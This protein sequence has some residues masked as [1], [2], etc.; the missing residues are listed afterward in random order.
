[1]R[2]SCTALLTKMQG[3][4]ARTLMRWQS[5]VRAS[6]AT[7]QLVS[8]ADALLAAGTL[9][10]ALSTWRTNEVNMKYW[11]AS[12]R[13]AVLHFLHLNLATVFWGWCDHAVMIKNQ[14]SKVKKAV[15]I[16]CRA[17]MSAA[18]N[19]W[20]HRTAALK[21]RM[22]LIN[23]G[24]MSL[25]PNELKAGLSCWRQLA[26]E[27][28]VQRNLLVEVA[29]SWSRRML[30]RLWGMWAKFTE[31]RQQ[32]GKIALAT[33]RCWTTQGLTKWRAR[34]SERR[35]S[36]RGKASALLYYS[37]RVSLMTFR[38]WRVLW[39]AI[40]GMRRAMDNVVSY[41]CWWLRT[42]HACWLARTRER[43]AQEHRA[44]IASHFVASQICTRAW[45]LWCECKQTVGVDHGVDAILDHIST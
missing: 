44:A 36:A 45:A 27:M 2:L 19:S 11:T 33:R 39:F 4:V 13:R 10:K 40:R 41:R 12:L 35:R 7:S 16:W 28:S 31:R 20:R 18:Y 17:S 29:V 3:E 26:V 14:K 38:Q 23:Q 5:H 1:M 24:L 15:S 30:T 9:G 22:R 34:G 8:S 37:E 6:I 42:A 21:Q 25:V 43:T 32:A